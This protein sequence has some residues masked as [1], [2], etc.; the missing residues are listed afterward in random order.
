MSVLN[1]TDIEAQK[2]ELA[3]KDK[4]HD[5]KFE[6]YLNTQGWRS[7]HKSINPYGLDDQPRSRNITETN[8]SSNISTE[9]GDDFT[10]NIFPD[11][12]DRLDAFDGEID[13]ISL[14][15]FRTSNSHSD[16][17][18]YEEP[19]NIEI[20][21]QHHIERV[22]EEGTTQEIDEFEEPEETNND[23][24]QPPTDYDSD[25]FAE[26]R[27]MTFIGKS[28]T[29]GVMPM[30]SNDFEY[31]KLDRQIRNKA[32]KP[33]IVSDDL[34]SGKPLNSADT[35]QNYD[36]SKNRNPEFNYSNLDNIIESQNPMFA[37]ENQPANVFEHDSVLSVDAL[38]QSKLDTSTLRRSHSDYYKSNLVILSRFRNLLILVVA[39]NSMLNFFEFQGESNID[40][41]C[42]KKEQWKHVGFVNLTFRMA[43]DAQYRHSTTTGEQFTINFIYENA[44]VIAGQPKEL[45]MVANDYSQVIIFEK[46]EL[47][48]A[49]L[50]TETKSEEEASADLKDYWNNIGEDHN[51]RMIFEMKSARNDNAIFKSNSTIF[52]YPIRVYSS[53]WSI[54]AHDNH[55]IVSD[56]SKR[57][58]IFELTEEGAI[59][60]AT[61][62]ELR[63]NIP[64]IDLK[65][66]NASMYIMVCATYAGLQ[67]ILMFNPKTYEFLISDC[68]ELDGSVWSCK[69]IPSSAFLEVT[70]FELLS[71]SLTSTIDPDDILNQSEILGIVSDQNES[72]D[73][74]LAKYYTHLK[75]PTISSR[76]IMESSSNSKIVKNEKLQL[77]RQRE[78]YDTLYTFLERDEN[79]IEMGSIV[80]VSVISGLDSYFISCTN[81]SIGLFNTFHML[82]LATCKHAFPMVSA[83]YIVQRN[84]NLNTNENENPF[85]SRRESHTAAESILP[86]SR[87]FLDRIYLIQPMFS[88][89]A[90]AIGTQAGQVSIFRL[91]KFRGLH[92][93]RLEYVLID[94]EKYIMNEHG[95]YRTLIGLTANKCG[96]DH[97]GNDVWLLA[98]VYSD[99]LTLNYKISKNLESED[100]SLNNELNIL[101]ML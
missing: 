20:N 92:S 7:R 27:F 91:C 3:L 65:R 98:V 4:L 24:P 36:R 38:S 2:R 80:D 50:T 100:K 47:M 46:D 61:S 10:Y 90:I 25:N 17:L 22:N 93:I 1:N 74:G 12:N 49:M 44:I 55:M 8:H 89:N 94:I 28:A 71:G 81:N 39:N 52:K 11:S 68:V 101:R 41:H 42:Y 70:S 77:Q 54:A 95:K 96:Y 34:D 57:V 23:I 37:L 26:K 64:F 31:F 16:G 5:E 60:K 48:N 45:L 19:A 97:I 63:H 43:D 75:V 83:P 29:Q 32:N 79:V 82:N 99:F 15:S 33:P 6:H 35:W 88:I 85:I 87:S 84:N 21:E 40:K 62:P 76:R 58:T 53:A 9:Y 13:R 66:V 78:L 69:F 14:L 59:Y 30:R 72:S 18:G 51:E 86:L 56:N 67:Y 73:L